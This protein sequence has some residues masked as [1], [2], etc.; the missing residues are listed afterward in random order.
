MESDGCASPLQTLPI[1]AAVPCLNPKQR[2]AHLALIRR[3]IVTEGFC[4]SNYVLPCGITAGDFALQYYFMTYARSMHNAQKQREKHN[5][6]VR[7]C[8]HF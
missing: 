7:S 4:S 2:K 5:E 6:T 3:Q 1:L 8:N